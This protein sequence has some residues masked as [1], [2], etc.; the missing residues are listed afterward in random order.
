V[1][2]EDEPGD[3]RLVAYVIPDEPSTFSARELKAFLQEK[4]PSYMVPTALMELDTFP[5]TPNGKVNRRAL[6]VPEPARLD[7]TEEGMAPQ[8]LMETLIAEIWREVLKVEQVGVLDNFLDLGGHS[9][10]I[11]QVI[12]RVE[13]Q[14][15]VRLRP[16]DVFTQTLGQLANM[17]EARKPEAFQPEGEDLQPAKAS[18]TLLQRLLRFGRA[19]RRAKSTEDA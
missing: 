8:T 12:Y 6:P 10:L 3:Q 18:Q 11:M 1:V 17:C 4:L 7:G 19:R 14:V 5:L 13:Q 9:L 15:G 2:R 16:L